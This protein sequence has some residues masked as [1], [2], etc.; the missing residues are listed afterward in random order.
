M[1]GITVTKDEQ[2]QQQFDA[3][4][5]TGLDPSKH[6]RWVRKDP[7]NVARQQAKGYVQTVRTPDMVHVV[8]DTTKIKKGE[9]TSTAIE[10]GDMILMETSQ[11]AFEA[12]QARKR[13]K[14]VRQTKGVTQ[15]YKEAIARMSR[16]EGQE[17]LG[18]EEHRPGHGYRD[19]GM[20][21][22]EV[23]RELE[24]ESYVERAPRIGV[25]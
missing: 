2:D 17:N 4:A 15:A 20:S 21:E 24:S 22:A 11:E 13:A 7:V 3:T 16:A 6:Y 25:R 23:Q 19:T 12:R 1:G 5:V 9:D 14:I 10:W 18:F 8:N